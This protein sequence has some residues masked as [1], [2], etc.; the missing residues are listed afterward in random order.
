[1]NLVT[2]Y[3]GQVEY[4]IFG[5][6]HTQEGQGTPH[7][8]GYVEFRSK[9]RFGAVKDI[10]T[11]RAHIEPR[12]GPQREAIEYCKKEGKYWEFGAPIPE[13]GT[14]QWDFIKQ[15]IS[16]GRTTTIYDRFP[17]TY[18][19]YRNAIEQEALENRPI[20]T[21]DG[22]LQTKNT[23][24]WGEAGVGK[25]KKVREIAGQDLYPKNCNKWW[26]GYRD[27]K[28]VVI[29]DL[30]PDRAKYLVQH[31][32]VWL[33]RY[34]FEAEV[35]GGTRLV[36][37]DYKLWITSNYSPEQCFQNPEDLEAIRRRLTV[38]HMVRLGN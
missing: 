8:Q 28:N 4:V 9:K 7:L 5:E 22:D 34:S 1:M 30:D 16:L 32:K 15:E 14:N 25:S 36:N 11:Q 31:L 38:E 37:P 26:D 2:L 18:M 17:A 20:L 13:A 27:Q 12:Q 33:D 23:W 6:E 10:L 21:W 24:I 3:P 35:K 29:E 19:R